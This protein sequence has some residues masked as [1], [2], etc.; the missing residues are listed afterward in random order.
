MWNTWRV[1]SLLVD[2][3]P[4]P[5]RSSFSYL[6]TIIGMKTFLISRYYFKLFK[7]VLKS[8]LDF[9]LMVLKWLFFSVL[10]LM[11]VWQM[12]VRQKPQKLFFNSQS[13]LRCWKDEDLTND[14][15]L[16]EDYEQHIVV[17]FLAVLSSLLFRSPHKRA[18]HMLMTTTFNFRQYQRV[19][20]VPQ[21]FL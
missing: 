13:V 21:S 16:L 11:L 3:I 15:G 19:K 9:L 20:T 2:L 1:I 14:G 10:F 8:I 5:W 7:V 4:L 18:K 17:V 12:C 6:G